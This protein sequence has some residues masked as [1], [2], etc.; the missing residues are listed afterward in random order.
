[1]SYETILWV[2]YLHLIFLLVDTYNYYFSS[3]PFKTQTQ[4]MLLLIQIDSECCQIYKSVLDAVR[5]CVVSGVAITSKCK[6]NFICVSI[7]MSCAHYTFIHYIYVLYMGVIFTSNM[8]NRWD[9]KRDKMLG[10]QYLLISWKH[11]SVSSCFL[12]QQISYKNH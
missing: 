6:T 3:W 7:S 9:K 4:R 2:S 12:I 11:L 8:G 1:M 5:S 10:W